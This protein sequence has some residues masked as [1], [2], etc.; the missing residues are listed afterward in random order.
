[1]RFSIFWVL[2]LIGIVY[3]FPL[4]WDL[5]WLPISEYITPERVFSTT[6]NLVDYLMQ[7]TNHLSPEFSLDDDIFIEPMPDDFIDL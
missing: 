2:V 6:N 1:M 7:P 3:I 4:I 5:V